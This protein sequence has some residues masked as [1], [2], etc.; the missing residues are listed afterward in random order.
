MNTFDKSYLR[1]ISYVILK[2][3]ISIYVKIYIK[4]II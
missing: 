1:D 3:H 4:K 2:E